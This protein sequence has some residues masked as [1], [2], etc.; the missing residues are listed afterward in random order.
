MKVGLITTTINVP[1]VLELYRAYGP[2]VR[3]F[4]ATD[5]KTPEAAIKFCKDLGNIDVFFFGSSPWK[6][7][8]IIGH[9]SIQRRNIALLEALKWGA[10]IIVT[11]DDD[12]QPLHYGYFSR[13]IDRLEF[14]FNG[15]RCATAGWFD[16][17]RLLEPRAKHRGVPFYMDDAPFRWDH[18]IGAKVGVAAGI[19]IGDPDVDAVTRLQTEPE[20]HRVSELLRAGI[21]TDPRTTTTVFN[22][23][24][25]C[26]LREL[27][28]AMM[29][30]PGCGR[31]DDIFASLICQ[32]VMRERGLH[33]HFGQPFVWQQ[34]N[35]HN[36]LKDLSNE[37]WGM[38][39]LPE[40]ADFLDRIIFG[41]G[42]V[43][44]HCQAIYLA[45]EHVP[46]FPAQATDCGLA[47]LQD[48]EAV[49][50]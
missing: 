28:P 31:Y 18:S 14:P 23:Q 16:V 11:I 10:E 27:A 8:E 7:F 12:N 13:F 35:E 30:L 25:T 2:D 4:V 32:R 46:W 34:R 48:C 39:H 38:E 20:V 9:N 45:L 40:F 44:E 50:K 22:S 43:I 24:N 33:V 49:M 15:I 29:M 17:G 47:F 41:P 5:V 37:I 21:V 36:L 26:F 42:T 6:C 3:F 19:C 1:R